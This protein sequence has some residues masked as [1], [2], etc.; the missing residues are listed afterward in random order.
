MAT[1][2]KVSVD[3]DDNPNE[4]PTN[5]YWVP[6]TPYKGKHKSITCGPLSPLGCIH[7]SDVLPCTPDLC[8]HLLAWALVLFIQC[9]LGRD[10]QLVWWRPTCALS[11]TLRLQSLFITANGYLYSPYE[12]YTVCEEGSSAD[13]AYSKLQWDWWLAE[14]R[15]VWFHEGRVAAT[16]HRWS[17]IHDKA[18]LTVLSVI[19]FMWPSSAFWAGPTERRCW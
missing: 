9:E 7:C 10:V 19:L 6:W 16:M 17:P 8:V 18:N 5:V 12:T 3:S 15:L 2:C 11:M 4:S 1:H 14:W 13:T